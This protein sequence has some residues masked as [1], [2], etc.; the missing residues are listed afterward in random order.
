MQNGVKKT[1]AKSRSMALLA[2]LAGIVLITPLIP[3]PMPGFVTG[4]PWKAELASSVFIF[5]FL[6][7][8]M[9]RHRDELMSRLTLLAD[10][11]SLVVITLLVFFV[12]WSALS[13]TW[14]A[15][16]RTAAHY[17]L[18]WVLYLIVVIAAAVSRGSKRFAIVAIG[19]VA[20][21]IAT[22]SVFDFLTSDFA[23]SEGTLRIRYARFAEML[24]TVTP[25]IW[26]AAIST[27]NIRNARY[28][29]LCAGLGWAAVMLSLSKGAFISGVVALGSMFFL[30]VAFS[31]H[32]RI[33]ALKVSAVWVTLTLFFQVGSS[34][35]IHAPATIDYISG[36]ADATR[37]TSKMR[38]FTWKVAEQMAADNLIV[39]V[40][41]DNFG[42]HFNESRLAY[43]QTHAADPD[44]AIGEDFMFERAHNE[45]LQILAELGIFGL[46]L[47]VLPFAMFSIWTV[48]RF[49]NQKHIPPV[50]LACIS[51][52]CGF[53][54]SSMVSSFSFR[55]VQ[56][57]LA[58]ALVFG[59]ALGYLRKRS[60]ASRRDV[61]RQTV[62]AF[63]LA[64]PAL[65]GALVLVAAFVCLSGSAG[66][67]RVYQYQAQ[68]AETFEEKA[69]LLNTSLA[70]DREN[71]AAYSSYAMAMAA[72]GDYTTAIVALRRSIDNGAGA[73]QVYSILAT[74]CLKAGD[75]NAAK[76]AMA[77]AVAIYP[78]SVFA[79]VRYA[80]MLELNGE[81]AAA[82][83]QI[84]A[85][86]AIDLR[87]SNG[88]I[89]LIRDGDVAAH[90]ASL[91]D[92]NISPPAELLPL[93][94]I[95][96]FVDRSALARIRSK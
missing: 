17:T 37:E 10:R 93:V 13:A 80:Q 33:R 12:L 79:R 43:A 2:I 50:F 9:G 58:F 11:S 23:V 67:S 69:E 8:L 53:A 44:L 71:A 26:A 1:D 89:A 36:K 65:A 7:W 27:R 16:P 19:S 24:V 45:P 48:R 22:S 63:S 30:I 31:R 81:H 32:Y 35:F 59:L 46:V 25:L 66:L 82:A 18:S 5:S 49:A 90:R 88:W 61:I 21:I 38:L 40:G 68:N 41:A 75:G 78:R 72:Q 84:A 77:E 96:Q 56:N 83:S 70:W 91:K 14:A 51:G 4:L 15:S 60:N 73:T 39:G 28:L 64:R 52:M 42:L 86:N 20:V 62:P 92:A 55:A 87:Q 54:I 74:L 95:Y 94:A 6:F 3:L 57:G 47:F 34:L 29:L 76:E 85:A